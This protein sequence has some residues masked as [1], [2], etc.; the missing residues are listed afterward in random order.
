M[1]ECGSAAKS[2]G[3]ST[4]PLLDTTYCDV[5]VP[6]S[7]R[8]A[9]TSQLIGAT[10][11]DASVKF[12]AS[13]SCT[14]VAPVTQLSGRMFSKSCDCEAQMVCGWVSVLA[15]TK[16]P[17]WK[18]PVRGQPVVSDHAPSCHVS[19]A[20]VLCARRYIQTVTLLDELTAVIMPHPGSRPGCSSRIIRPT[21]VDANGL[22]SPCAVTVIEPVVVALA[23]NSRA[24]VL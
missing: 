21:S 13:S 18:V 22:K 3:V 16:R 24:R 10:R 19:V 6:T 8:R 2:D 5:P 20:T 23:A 12:S 7:K 4:A 17:S 11:E 15:A 9:L 1:D 14:V